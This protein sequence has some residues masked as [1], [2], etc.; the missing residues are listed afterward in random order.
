MLKTY[1]QNPQKLKDFH[2]KQNEKQ[3]LKTQYLSVVLSTL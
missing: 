1:K 3:G 2:N